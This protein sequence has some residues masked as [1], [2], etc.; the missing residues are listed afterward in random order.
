LRGDGIVLQVFS[1]APERANTAD[2]GDE[3]A[4]V[5]RELSSYEPGSVS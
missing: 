4:V 5:R 3:I 2:F 1:A